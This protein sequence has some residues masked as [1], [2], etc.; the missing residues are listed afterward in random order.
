MGSVQELASKAYEK[1]AE[2]QAG[3]SRPRRLPGGRGRDA[4]GASGG[5]GGDDSVDA[6]YEEVDDKR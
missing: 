4:T 6:D 2:A 1:A 3:A 5:A